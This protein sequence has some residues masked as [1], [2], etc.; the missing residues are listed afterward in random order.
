MVSNHFCCVFCSH[1]LCTVLLVWLLL[2]WWWGGGTWQRD[3]FTRHVFP[4]LNKRLVSR[5]VRVV[6][7][8]LRWGLTAEDTSDNGLGALEH[9]LLAIDECRPFFVLLTGE[10]YGWR[11][12][13]YRVRELPRWDWVREFEPGHRCATT[14]LC[15]TPKRC[16]HAPLSL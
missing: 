1:V 12:P 2:L 3:S 11:P 10:R 4:A 8:D 14:L 15:D 9:C 7:L 6:P 13:G 5:R 16:C